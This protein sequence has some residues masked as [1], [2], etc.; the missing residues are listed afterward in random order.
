MEIHGAR[1]NSRSLEGPPQI[2]H[3]ASVSGI[4]ASYT[5]APAR[6]G[7]WQ[8]K[9]FK[10]RS[11]GLPVGMHNTGVL[12]RAGLH[13][14]ISAVKVQRGYRVI[15]YKDQEGGTPKNVM[16]KLEGPIAAKDLGAPGPANDASAIKV[17]PINSSSE[18]PA[19]NGS[20]SGDGT[21][22]QKTPKV[23]KTGFGGSSFVAVL[24]GLGLLGAGAYTIYLNQ[25]EQ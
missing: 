10:G 24:G 11:L 1:T 16:T 3:P 12:N 17:E 4:P 21:N 5:S 8:F 18:E 7:V 23:K 13:D 9:G 15:L 25:Q 2:N 20:S 19:E 14:R 22:Q 6:V